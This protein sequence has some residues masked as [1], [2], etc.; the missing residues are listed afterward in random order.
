MSSADDPQTPHSLWHDNKPLWITLIVVS[1]ILATHYYVHKT[2]RYIRFQREPQHQEQNSPP[3]DFERNWGNAM[4]V[5]RLQRVFIQQ[6]DDVDLPA[7][8]Y[9]GHIHDEGV[10]EDVKLEKRGKYHYVVQSGDLPPYRIFEEH[11]Y[12]R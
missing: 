5:Q 1:I 3:T 10:P 9:E 4:T 12:S 2:C 6:G 11:R 8:R 7:P